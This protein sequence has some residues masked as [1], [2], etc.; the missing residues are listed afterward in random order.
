MVGNRDIKKL[1]LHFP[2]T[3]PEL[4]KIVLAPGEK[5]R[6]KFVSYINTDKLDDE[7]SVNDSPNE[8]TSVDDTS[9]KLLSIKQK[10][11]YQKDYDLGY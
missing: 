8:V 11:K 9:G 1:K 3:V 7:E 10:E 2:D 6:E 4:T 5:Q